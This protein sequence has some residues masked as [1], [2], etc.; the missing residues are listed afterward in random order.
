LNIQ[1]K[2]IKED[3]ISEMMLSVID[4]GVKGILREN[5]GIFN[6]IRIIDYL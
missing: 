1:I 2:I 6:F 3:N 5:A 4:V